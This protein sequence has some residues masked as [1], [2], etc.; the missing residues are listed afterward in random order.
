MSASKQH[1]GVLI[2]ETMEA[3]AVQ[4]DF[5]Y[6]DATFG[7]GGHSREIL[8]LG[9]KVIGFDFDLEAIDRA[10][11]EFA[12][13]IADERLILRRENFKNLGPALENLA[14]TLDFAVAGILF[15]FGTSTDQL[16]SSE[17]GF[18]F[19]ATEGATLDMRMD[20]DLGVKAADLLIILGEKQL[21][22]VLFQ[23]GGE[24]DARRIARAV[25]Q[26]R[27]TNPSSLNYVDTLVK[28]VEKVKGGGRHHSKLHPATKTFQALR[29]AVNDELNNISEALPAAFAVLA[30]S[31]AI[32]KR[33]VCIAFHEG[34]DRL[35]KNYFK[36][37][38]DQ[39]LGKLLHKKPIMA[40]EAELQTNPR[41][42]SAKLRVLAI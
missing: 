28:I 25:A 11:T 14:K 24:V 31:S 35:V 42:R 4:K 26:V 6:V 38:A 2:A 5:W 29:I 8:N 19:E 10:K 36:T 7:R 12:K 9:G 18:S 39:N 15:D 27:K 33:L 3:L 32:N 23:Y 13:E 17:R 30:E 41:S 34:E 20:Q 40:S 16:M 1:Q 37:Q 21:A 22:E